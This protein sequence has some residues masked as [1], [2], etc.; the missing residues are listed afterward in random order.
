[1]AIF[2]LRRAEVCRRL[3]GISATVFDEYFRRLDDFP[4]PIMLS[5]RMPG[6]VESEIDD[7]LAKRIAD[8]DG[9]AAA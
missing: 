1:M 4:K 6:W 3:G 5:A 9:K 8:R 7:W 2:V